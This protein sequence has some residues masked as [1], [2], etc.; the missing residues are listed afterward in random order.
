ML[1]F[2]LKYKFKYIKNNNNPVAE[3]EAVTGRKPGKP[4]IR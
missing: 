2:I 3:P 1:L 4:T